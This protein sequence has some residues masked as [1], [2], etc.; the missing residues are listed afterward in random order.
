[1]PAHWWVRLISIPLVD[2]V[3]SLGVIRGGYVPVSL[4][5][6]LT[7]GGAVIPPGLLFGLWLLSADG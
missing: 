2:G 3:L 4:G 6:L 7:G 1:M 5:S